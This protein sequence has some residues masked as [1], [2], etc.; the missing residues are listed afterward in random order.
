MWK[1]REASEGFGFLVFP[2][3]RHQYKRQNGP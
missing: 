1:A 2:G 3:N